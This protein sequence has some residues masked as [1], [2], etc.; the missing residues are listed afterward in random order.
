MENLP[1]TLSQR[2]HCKWF[3]RQQRLT[4]LENTLNG[5]A[6]FV[7]S[8]LTK[9]ANKRSNKLWTERISVARDMTSA[10]MFMH[11]K[12]VLHRDI[13]PNNIGFDAD[14]TFKLFDF[15]NSH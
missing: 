10:L 6:S 7:P 1:G 13:K 5:H 12:S 9:K 11:I 4:K 15:W 2:I 8:G 3:K 14:G